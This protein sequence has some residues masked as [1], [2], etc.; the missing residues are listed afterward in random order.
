M[1]LKI[2]EEIK[3]VRKF[4]IGKDYELLIISEKKNKLIGRVELEAFIIHVGKGTPK[5][6]ILRKTIASHYNKSE[7]LIIFRKIE[8][9]FGIGLSKAEIHIYD[10]LDR[11]RLFE[12]KHILKRHERKKMEGGD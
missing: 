11:L 6:D 1:S 10:N 8:S 2:L 7:D 12:P 3:P 9:S 4:S 5:R